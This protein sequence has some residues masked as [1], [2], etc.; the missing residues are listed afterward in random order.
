VEDADGHFCTSC[1]TGDYPLPPEEG[2]G[3]RRVKE[4]EGGAGGKGGEA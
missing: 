4:R 3:E 1:Y 2:T